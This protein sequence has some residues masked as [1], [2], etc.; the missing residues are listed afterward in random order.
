MTRGIG[1]PRPAAS[2]PRAVD[3]LNGRVS[4]PK[5]PCCLDRSST[6]R[7]CLIP[8]VATT[9]AELSAR[10][11]SQP[12]LEASR[13]R[14]Q[15]GTVVRWRSRYS[16]RTM[17]DPAAVVFPAGNRS[18]GCGFVP[19]L[20]LGPMKRLPIVSSAR[21]WPGDHMETSFAG[22]AEDLSATLSVSARERLLPS[23]P[24][25]SRIERL[26]CR[27]RC[28]HP[29]SGAPRLSC[30]PASVALT[31]EHSGPVVWRTWPRLARLCVHTASSFPIRKVGTDRGQWH[32]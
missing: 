7:V 22:F 3:L 14:R 32:C 26:R 6:M 17:V 9:H 5:R 24:W 19:M 1:A 25:R 2:L 13:V 29:T 12:R 20:G 30:A 28:G 16:F 11:A 15:R 8:L 10:V 4:G 31:T 18:R 21:N 23:P 27:S